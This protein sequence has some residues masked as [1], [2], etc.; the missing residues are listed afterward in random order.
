LVLTAKV[1]QAIGSLFVPDI[2]FRKGGMIV[3]PIL[4]IG[5]GFILASILSPYPS[6]W[7]GEIG[8]A[9]AS[10]APQQTTIQRINPAGSTQPSHYTHLVRAGNTLYLSGQV[11]SNE[12]GEVV[13]KGDIRAQVR[14]VFENLKRVLAS[15][16]A[17]FDNLLKI[18]IFAVNIDEFRKAGDIRA[19][20]TSGRAPA[21]L[22]N[23]D[24]LI[25]IEGIAVLE[26]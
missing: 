18:T 13:G 15:Q 4:F 20:Y 2:P 22:A 8:E 3:R 10:E 25:E 23:P 12:K 14:Q 7:R 21:S 26:Q 5:F 19:E 17:T 9:M 16:G 24:Y 1:G 11:A 6:P